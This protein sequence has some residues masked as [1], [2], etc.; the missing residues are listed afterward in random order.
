MWKLTISVLAL[1]MLGLNK[2]LA[3][4]YLHLKKHF[5]LTMLLV[6][7]FFLVCKPISAR[8]NQCLYRQVDKPAFFAFAYRLTIQLANSFK[9]LIVIRNLGSE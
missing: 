5:L 4:N 7:L 1:K 2:Q 8:V 6:I 3:R 9:Y